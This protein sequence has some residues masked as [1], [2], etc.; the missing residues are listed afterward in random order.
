MKKYS[1]S[2]V[3]ISL[4]NTPFEN[5]M[6][7]VFFDLAETLQWQVIFPSLRGMVFG[8][9]MRDYSKEILFKRSLFVKHEKENGVEKYYGKGLL[10]SFESQVSG[11][12]LEDNL[13]L[14]FKGI[15]RTNVFKDYDIQIKGQECKM[16]FFQEFYNMPEWKTKIVFNTNQQKLFWQA[17]DY[18]M[19]VPKSLNESEWANKQEDESP[20]K[21]LVWKDYKVNDKELFGPLDVQWHESDF[22]LDMKQFSAITTERI[23]CEKKGEEVICELNE[24][25]FF[26]SNCDLET[27][28]N[29]LKNKEIVRGI[30]IDGTCDFLSNH[31]LAFKEVLIEKSSEC[32]SL[33]CER[34]SKIFNVLSDLSEIEI[35]D[36]N[37]MKTT[38][39]DGKIKNASI[40][41]C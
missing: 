23:M 4:L 37:E 33:S 1:L 16:N 36:L 9:I 29:Y 3:Q 21:F 2:S 22:F 8:R 41:C 20:Y 5:L 7:C 15:V 34:S 18:E 31:L 17:T 38:R 13:L 25:M 24:E 35:N 11:N 6:K 40:V 32:V 30:R 28:I 27:I 10:N 26:F 12:I 39:K 14:D 19:Q